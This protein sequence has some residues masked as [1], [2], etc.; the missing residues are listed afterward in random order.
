MCCGSW[1]IG[2]VAGVV[3]APV[4]LEGVEVTDELD[5]V[6][7]GGPGWDSDVFRLVFPMPDDRRG[8]SEMAESSA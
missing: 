6:G 1:G 7:D 3:G 5:V 8:C 4:D 2:A